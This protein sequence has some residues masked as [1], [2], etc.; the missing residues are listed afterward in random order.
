MANTNLGVLFRVALLASVMV[1]YAFEASGQ[2]E[3]MSK[4]K[5][6]V[7]ERFTYHIHNHLDTYSQGIIVA[8]NDTYSDGT[9]TIVAIDSN[10]DVSHPSVVVTVGY[11]GHQLYWFHSSSDSTAPGLPLIIELAK[12][13][14]V[15]FDFSKSSST[16]AKFGLQT[17]T[18]YSGDDGTTVMEYAPELRW[19]YSLHS[20]VENMQV[21][22]PA[23][24]GYLTDYTYTLTSAALS[25]ASSQQLG[26]SAIRNISTDEHAKLLDLDIMLESAH[27]MRCQLLDPLARPI[28][29]WSLDVAAGESQVHL[30]V[31]DVPS[32]VYFLRVSAAGM[33]Q[34]RKVVIVH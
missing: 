26:V 27:Q 10:V 9:D 15:R 24:T 22:G 28:R 2:T 31:T 30:N 34:V 1:L 12:T 18:L 11:S 14:S 4:W 17:L 13:P 8:S 5:P 33:E 7:G 21:S 19:F 23:K 32:G 29:S 16:S 25:V 20:I 3:P 6:K